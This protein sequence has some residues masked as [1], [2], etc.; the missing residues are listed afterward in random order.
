MRCLTGVLFFGIAA[1]LGIG[2]FAQSPSNNDD[3]S[4][5]RKEIRGVEV[6]VN[7]VQIQR[8]GPTAEIPDKLKISS[9]GGDELTRTIAISLSQK[10]HGSSTGPTHLELGNGQKL[11]PFMNGNQRF[12]SVIANAAV[13]QGFDFAEYWFRVPSETKFADIFPL[14]IV[15]NTTNDRQEK[16]EFRFED[17]E[18]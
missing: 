7:Q 6:L 15:H 3:R 17:I 4:V 13:P 10:G 11:S 1:Y 16:V 14:T 2:G 9:F 18:P 12:M 8:L 5:A